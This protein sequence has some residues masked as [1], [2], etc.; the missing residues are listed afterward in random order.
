MHHHSY[1]S[2]IYIWPVRGSDAPLIMNHADEFR[3]QLVR[4]PVT[5]ALHCHAYL[6]ISHWSQICINKL[7]LRGLFKETY[8]LHASA[9]K[10]RMPLKSL[11]A[12]KIDLM[13]QTDWG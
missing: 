3:L 12:C 10:G 1:A 8:N 7:A 2:Y 9:G 13:P 5:G 4:E 11:P 6:T